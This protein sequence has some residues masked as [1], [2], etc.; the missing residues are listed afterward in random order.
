MLIRKLFFDLSFPCLPA[1]AG[2]WQG[3]ERRL[4]ARCKASATWSAGLAVLLALLIGVPQLS[5]ASGV[6]PHE[7]AHLRAGAATA[8]NVA[9]FYRF[10]DGISTGDQVQVTAHVR[11]VNRGRT[12]AVLQNLLL[13]HGSAPPQAP[14]GVDTLSLGP[15]GKAEF[16]QEMMISASEYGSQVPRGR[17]TLSFDSVAAGQTVGSTIVLHPQERTRSKARD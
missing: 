3:F 9:G 15:R 14:Q 13:G 17:L 12:E 10:S 11:L 4:S 8:N 1:K 7:A 6:T 5:A 16:T 2:T